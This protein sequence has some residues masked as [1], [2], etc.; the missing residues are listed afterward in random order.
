MQDCIELPEIVVSL[1]SVVSVTCHSVDINLRAAA[2]SVVRDSTGREIREP[3]VKHDDLKVG[4]NKLSLHYV[5]S[6]FIYTDYE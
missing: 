4:N 1:T 3:S 6:Q 5:T 2:K